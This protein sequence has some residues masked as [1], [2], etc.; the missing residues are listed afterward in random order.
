MSE[1]SKDAQTR[2]D[3]EAKLVYDATPLSPAMRRVLANGRQGES[4]NFGIPSKNTEHQG[5]SIIKN[6]SKSE[7]G[8]RKL[9]YDDSG[10]PEIADNPDH[11]HLDSREDIIRQCLKEGGNL[12]KILNEWVLHDVGSYQKES[13]RRF[14]QL[15][16]NSS[17]PKLELLT[18]LKASGVELND[19]PESGETIGKQFNV[20]RQAV[21]KRIIGAKNKLGLPDNTREAKNSESRQIYK[22]NN[23]RN[24][25]P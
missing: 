4:N 13:I 14:A 20:T 19:N 23:N 11:S 16:L 2:R 17:N 15:L 24:Y 22:N 10:N 21:S 8:A 1:S 7:P 12:N 25:K 18:I 6:S 9:F 3:R 5:I